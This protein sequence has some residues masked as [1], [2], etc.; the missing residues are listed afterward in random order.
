MLS[1]VWRRIEE[2]FWNF[3]RSWWELCKHILHALLPTP[4]QLLKIVSRILPSRNAYHH[5]SGDK[6]AMLLSSDIQTSWIACISGYA[7][8]WSSRSPS[9][10]RQL[11]CL[12]IS[13][14]TNCSCRL[15]L[16][17][18]FLQIVFGCL[19]SGFLPEIIFDN[20]LLV[21]YFFS[22]FGF[23]NGVVERRAQLG[24]DAWVEYRYYFF[25]EMQGERVH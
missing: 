17:N 8:F 24:G 25:A 12:W 18:F 10:I 13:L 22:S 15:V 21:Q 23:E 4:Q 7:S 5:S 1:V 20:L 19:P 6:F 14:I 9:N 2:N 11:Y 16:L 3:G